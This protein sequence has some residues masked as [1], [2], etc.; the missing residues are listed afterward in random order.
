VAT[1]FEL[2][3]AM[4]Y[5]DL[6]TKLVWEDTA[7]RDSVHQFAKEII[8]PAARQLDR[9]TAEEVV[10]PGSPLYDVLRMLAKII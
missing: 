8:R 9:M 5:F 2:G 10:A 3:V 7:V 6:N 1:T 4:P